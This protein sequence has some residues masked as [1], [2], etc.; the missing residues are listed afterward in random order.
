GLGTGFEGRGPLSIV[1]RTL[2]RM[3]LG[4]PVTVFFQNGEDRATLLRLGF[5]REDQAD[6]VPGSGIPLDRLLPTPFRRGRPFVF[7][8]V[9]RLLRQ[10]GVGDFVTAATLVKRDF[11][12]AEFRIAGF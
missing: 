7:L 11:P 1:L 2:Y 8:F 5:V 12:D 6:Q 10:K 9:S 3:A 4:F